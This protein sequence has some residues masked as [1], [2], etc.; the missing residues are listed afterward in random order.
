MAA[1]A[2]AANSNVRP[3]RLE[4]TT[5]VIAFPSKRIWRKEFDTTAPDSVTA[6]LGTG[7]GTQGR[8]RIA[9]SL[10]T[11]VTLSSRFVTNVYA[12]GTSSRSVTA[13]GRTGRPFVQVKIRSRALVLPPPPSFASP[14]R[15]D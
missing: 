1:S 8:T 4:T 14:P 11:T 7:S 13:D 12:D 6:T 5:G 9:A 10:V 2:A 15:S 3:S